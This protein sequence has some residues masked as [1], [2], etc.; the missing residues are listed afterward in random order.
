MSE[1]SARKLRFFAEHPYCCFCGGFKP[2]AEPDHVPGRAF[3]N[4]RQWP[5]G[6]EFPACVECNRATRRDEQAVAML[7]RIYPD[8]PT[9][10]EQA[11]VH[12]LM[13]E[14][15][16]NH[17]GLFSE[18]QPSIRQLRAATRKYGLKPAA[19]QP[20]D[21]LPVLS[22]SGPLVNEAIRQFSRKLLCALF[23][24]HTGHILGP[25]G[26]MAMRWYANIQINADEID[27]AIAEVT[28]H[29]PKLERN[30]K[31]LDGQFFYRWGITDTKR[32]AAFLVFFRQTF[33]ILGIVTQEPES[34]PIPDDESL[35]YPFKH[36]TT[37]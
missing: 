2:S 21:S 30:A 22:V 35:L 33:A 11:A 12:K 34:L 23:Y 10:E 6:Y 24:K 8:A 1:K 18:M 29:A 36:T 3:F 13:G 25:A 28:P 15:H 26:G 27:R 16:R 20:L 37:P 9:A 14:V 7:S 5:V 31:A 17:P 4:N 19:G 32:M